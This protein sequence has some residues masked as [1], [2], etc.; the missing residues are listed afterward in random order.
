MQRDEAMCIAGKI[1]WIEVIRVIA[2]IFVVV[3]H[4]V[5]TAIHYFE[6]TAS[7]WDFFVYNG[8]NHFARFAVP[9]FLMI[10]GYLLLNPERKIDYKKVL[11][12]YVWRMVVI[13]FTVGSVFA[14]MELYFDTRSCNM[15]TFLNAFWKVIIGK[16]W[17]HMWYLYSL[18]GLY[19]VCPVIKPAF[20]NL[21]TKTIDI[22]L[23]LGF[24]FCCIIPTLNRMTG[25]EFGIKYPMTSEFVYYFLLG[26]RLFRTKE[27]V[28]TSWWW[29]SIAFVFGIFQFGVSF[30]EY[31]IGYTPAE[32]LKDYASPFMAIY[33]FA[34]FIWVMKSKHFL[35][36]DCRFRGWLKLLSINS[37]GIYVF[38]MLWIN[39]IYK[40]MKYNP[41]S[42]GLW[43]IPLLI[44]IVTILSLITSIIFRKIPYVGKYI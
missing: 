3:N 11:T 34:V 1:K 33:S 18:I 6:K 27:G 22:F 31:Y 44:I 40:V 21:D 26:G 19:L 23:L 38:H 14:M 42:E 36:L 7:Q 35:L 9:C 8:I 39:V 30:L 28:L 43:T 2:T 17:G 4:V 32:W 15:L 16:T 25:F 24:V 29:L 37:F 5:I 12:K 10:T 13:L 20:N 41:I